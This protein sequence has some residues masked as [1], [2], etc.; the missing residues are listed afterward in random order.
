MGTTCLALKCRVRPSVLVD[1]ANRYTPRF[2]QRHLFRFQRVHSTVEIDGWSR[3]NARRLAIVV[4]M[5]GAKGQD[6]TG[7]EN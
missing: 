4:G 6:C 7:F 3:I 2:A 1:K 5:N